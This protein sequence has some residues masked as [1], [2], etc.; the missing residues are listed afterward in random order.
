[1]RIAP[2]KKIEDVIKSFFCYNNFINRKSRLF[3]VGLLFLDKYNQELTNLIN[4][5]DLG[6]CVIFT[7]KVSILDL[8]TYYALSS[9]FICMSEH[10]GFCVPLLE[11][12]YFELP[13]LAYNSTAIP[14]TLEKSGILLNA[15]KYEEIA[16][17]INLIVE[18]SK[19]R[20]QLIKRQKERL[21][22]FSPDNIKTKLKEILETVIQ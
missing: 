8:K 9:A 16:E 21:H 22:D 19:M 15:K 17:M 3:L 4:R 10:E 5:L 20:N 6:N 1:G 7:N 12:M 14:F 18:D 11:S 13:I 2:N